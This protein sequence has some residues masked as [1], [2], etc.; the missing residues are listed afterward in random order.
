MPQAKRAVQGLKAAAELADLCRKRACH[1]IFRELRV[2]E[3]TELADLRWELAC[4]VVAADGEPCKPAELV[5]KHVSHGWRVLR[6]NWKC[7]MCED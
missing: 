5:R 7:H 4:E 3:A 2:A 1:V 6:L